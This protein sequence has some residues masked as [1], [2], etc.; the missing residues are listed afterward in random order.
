MQTSVMT[1]RRT[2]P[3]LSRRPDAQ[4]LRAVA[5]VLIV[6]GTLGVSGVKGGFVGIDV[7]FVLTGFLTTAML[8]GEA[9][10]TRR[11][12]V[13]GFYAR[14][15]RR[16]F[17][18]I[19]LVLLVTVAGT[20][21]LVK[22][23]DQVGAI[24]SEALWAVGLAANWKFVLNGVGYDQINPVSPIQHFWAIAVG[25]Q[26]FLVWPLL[27]LAVLFLGSRRRPFQRSYVKR[28]G[29]ARVLGFGLVVLLLGAGSFGYALLSVE[30]D[31]VGYFSSATRLWEFAAGAMLA[32][33]IG[34]LRDVPG[35]VKAAASWIGLVGIVASAALLDPT[36]SFPGVPALFPVAATLL[37]L[38]GGIDGPAY[39]AGG[40]LGLAPVRWLGDRALGIYLWHLPALV[41]AGVYVARP[42][43]LFESTVVMIGVVVL[44]TVTHAAYERP[45]RSGPP[46]N[47]NIG[48]VL[49]P[50]SIALVTVVALVALDAVSSAPPVVAVPAAPTSSS[51][52]PTTPPPD[53]PPTAI[54]AIANGIVQTVTAA[55]SGD[56][57]S[58]SVLNR[59]SGL[60]ADTWAAGA[61]CASPF[62]STTSDIC[63]YGPDNAD[64]T[65]VIF[66]D[67]Q[68]GAWVP[69]LRQ[70]AENSGWKF[71]YFVKR[72]CSA[73][74]VRLL[75]AVRQNREA[76]CDSWRT[77]AID[78]IK[79]LKPDLTMIA[80]DGSV[81]VT[82]EG[83][84]RLSASEQTDAWEA[85]TLATLQTL[86][87]DLPRVAAF[88]QV[89]VGPDPVVCLNQKNVKIA[90]CTFLAGRKTDSINNA[91][92]RAV[93]TSGTEFVDV[94]GLLCAQSKCP[95]YNIT[96]F[97]YFSP[98][99]L[100]ASYSR[101]LSPALTDL[102][103]AG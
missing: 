13:L 98:G 94:S 10:Q 29:E 40:V 78:Q 55:D 24:V 96:D 88:G 85:G 72:Q 84:K 51:P 4:G 59:L 70:V 103:G 12:D 48:L 64:R 91:T 77:W 37:V 54:E 42:L 97:I 62:G 21:F 25:E 9:N 41:L 19:T 43:N 76:E 67:E 60:A 23:N 30:P 79:K 71:Y 99:Q 83:D 95:P 82:G 18:L 74:Q 26:F 89:P 6:L 65:M 3:R 46:F 44:A 102:L 101:R 90:D 86:S 15:A 61:P 50:A 47:G 63:S 17:P 34:R 68:A 80:N 45:L 39:G 20:Y 22:N 73:V 66:G 1:E 75:D 33:G 53:N 92:Q 11:L 5:V 31:G 2:A 56:A 57:V 8:L 35:P 87:A 16:L 14:R 93:A 32:I 69:A 49:W 36:A 58:G 27:M 7:F 81:T 52:A 100:T 28:P 38:A